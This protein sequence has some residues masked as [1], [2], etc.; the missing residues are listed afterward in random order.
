VGALHGAFYE[1]RILHAG[2]AILCSLLY[3][4]PGFSEYLC[5]KEK[6]AKKLYA[7]NWHPGEF[8]YQQHIWQATLSP[9]V[10]IFTSPLLGEEDRAKLDSGMRV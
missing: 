6:V 4:R 1:Y 10:T 9:D 2:W 3:F 5:K 7:D 8:G